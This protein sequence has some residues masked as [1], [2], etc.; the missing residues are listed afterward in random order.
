MDLSPPEIGIFDWV[1]IFSHT[2]VSAILW[3]IIAGLG[4]LGVLIVYAMCT[5]TKSEESV[6]YHVA[7]AQRRRR[8]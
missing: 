7:D 1:Y 3:G 4:L 2:L 6:E 5:H 8:S